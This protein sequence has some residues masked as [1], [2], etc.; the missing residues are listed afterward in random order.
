MTSL[1]DVDYA[2]DQENNAQ[3]RRATAA[4]LARSKQRFG[5]FL[6]GGDIPARFDLME[7]D[8]KQVVADV[9]AEYG[10]D[11]D[12]V[13]SA[14]TSVL[15]AG[16]YCDTCK[17][18]KSGPR[19]GNCTCS[20]GSTREHEDG[21]SESADDEAN[22]DDSADAGSATSS[23]KTAG[24]CELCSDKAKD[25]VKVDGLRLCPDCRGV[26]TDNESVPTDDDKTSSTM[27]HWRL[28]GEALETEK[29]PKVPFGGDTL[30]GPSPKMD[31]KEWKP[32]ALNGDGNLKPIDTEGKGSP[33]PTEKHDIAR[34][35]DHTRDPLEQTRGGKGVT[36]TE[37]LKGHDDPDKA[38]FDTK[39]NITQY[40]TRTFGDKGEQSSAVGDEAFPKKSSDYGDFT[41]HPSPMDEQQERVRH[42]LGRCPN[43]NNP[44]DPPQC[45]HCGYS[46]QQG[47][48][49]G[50]DP[51]Q[52]Y[53]G[54][55]AMDDPDQGM[56]PYRASAPKKSDVSPDGTTFNTPNP[57]YPMPEGTPPPGTPPPAP[58][59]TQQAQ[60]AQQDAMHGIFP[61]PQTG[62]MGADA[63]EEARW[64]QAYKNWG[65]GGPH[66][67]QVV[68]NHP[69]SQNYL[70]NQNQGQQ[71]LSS[72]DPDRNPIRESLR[73]EHGVLPQG[74]L[75]AAISNFRS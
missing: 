8:F 11:A 49:H 16:G 54:G 1:F 65:E 42:L 58:A 62:P 48:E 24:E 52:Q 14:V 27:S 23:V 20:G 4:A 40:P 71:P 12:R 46:E 45:P 68:P 59:P 15:S 39:K 56:Q 60:P 9:I 2:N 18:W 34:S 33:H 38:G 13:E 53:G 70:Q 41:G 63:D 47:A 55:H 35:T 22:A 61:H 43:C 29:L 28:V 5:A 73:A 69:W 30:D 32:N 6:S 37:T 50:G 66:P 51:S 44:A 21:P 25:L 31:K 67:S 10:G 26:G 17:C 19:A 7:S 36:E 3:G 74:E 75:D 64:Q 57:Y 72:S